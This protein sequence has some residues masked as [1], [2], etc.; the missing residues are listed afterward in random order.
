MLWCPSVRPTR[1]PDQREKL[2]TTIVIHGSRR[3]FRPKREE[4]LGTKESQDKKGS[5]QELIFMWKNRSFYSQIQ[6]KK[7]GGKALHH[8][9]S[10]SHKVI[11]HEVGIQLSGD[12]QSK[13]I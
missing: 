2:E 3:G 12:P 6:T 10:E 11:H 8:V 7:M 5:D 4:G 1:D 13:K 9:F